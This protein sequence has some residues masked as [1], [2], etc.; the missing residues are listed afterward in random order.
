MPVP[1]SELNAQLND[2]LQPAQFDDYCPNGMQVEGAGTV[3]TLISGVTASRALINSAIDASADALLVHHGYF[4]RG[5]SQPIIGMKKERIKLL[6]ENE[7]SLFAYHLPL[8]FHAELG[9]NAQLG[10][11]MGARLES[12]IG[13]PGELPLVAVGELEQPTSAADFSQILTSVLKRPPLWLPGDS[14]PVRKLGWCT[15]AAQNYFETAI[16]SGVDAFVTGEVSEPSAHLARESGVH[17]FAAGHHAT[18]RYGV[19]AVGEFLAQKLDIE[20]R[21][22]N[23]DNPV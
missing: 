6:L 2:L 22:I 13:K 8:D 12:L 7:I 19:M 3:R 11:H 18:E 4:W 16:D 20:H 5:E 23:I 10:K 15:G 14:R 9:N 17:F 1:L 21:F